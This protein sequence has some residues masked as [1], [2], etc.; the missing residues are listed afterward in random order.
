M[1]GDFGSAV[2]RKVTLRLVPFLLV[3][4][5]AAY[6]DRINVGFA[7]LQIK[8]DLGFP[9]AVYGLGA[10]LFFVGYFLFEIPSN[11]VLERV[12]ARRWIA[13]IMV[14]W[15]LVSAAMMF[16][17][18]AGPFYV[19][20]FLLGAAEAGFFPG[21]ILYLTYWFP[22]R[23]RARAISKFMTASTLAWILG[24]PVS[25]MILGLDGRAGLSGWRWLF[26]LEGIPSVLLAGAVLALLPDRPADARW[27]RPEEKEWLG[28]QLAI[29]AAAGRERGDLRAALGD[30][31][32]WRITLVYVLLSLG[33][34]G[35]SLWL[36]QVLQAAW[37]GSTLSTGFLS[38]VPYIATAL[39]MIAI[40]THSDRSGER[41]WH[42]AGPALAASLGLVLAG[43]SRRPELALA[44]L[45]LSASGLFGGLG[46]FWALAT[47]RL[48][49]R[50]AAG[51]IA[52]VNSVGKLGGFLGP[53]LVG[54]LK[55]GKDDYARGFALL[56]GTLAAAAILALTL[57]GA[58]PSAPPS[59][60]GSPAPSPVACAA[61]K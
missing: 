49:P 24:G 37:G 18:S 58:A 22:P 40:G 38:A 16:V 56:A 55:E 1:S 45:C 48:S 8:R 23:E 52:F 36:P 2:L 29:P 57:R 6:L 39:S 60:S 10:S 61:E 11:L 28:A 4:Y 30:P 15:G 34:Y 47:E 43:V 50:S 12:G 3:L 14:T 46:P 21:I 19:L 5:V 51:G 25:G 13:R 41:R 20:R 54:L 17:R 35:F 59:S 27:L 42:V 9:D 44:A 53:Y 31:S 26:L 32:V 33:G 7:A